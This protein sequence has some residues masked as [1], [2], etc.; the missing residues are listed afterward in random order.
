MEHLPVPKYVVQAWVCDYGIW[1]LEDM[2]FVGN[3]IESFR[4]ASVICEWLVKSDLTI[5]EVGQ[6]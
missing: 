3:P 1:D 4:D 5:E 2:E 6:S